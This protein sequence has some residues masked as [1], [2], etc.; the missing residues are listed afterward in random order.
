MNSEHVE[1]GGQSRSSSGEDMVAVR[2]KVSSNEQQ[3]DSGSACGGS[4]A[5]CG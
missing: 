3:E 2:V 4:E 5:G 1:K